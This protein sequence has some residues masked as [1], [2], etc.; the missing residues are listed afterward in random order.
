MG[1]G[2]VRRRTLL[3]LPALA[4]LSAAASACGPRG[5][6]NGK[7]THEFMNPIMNSGADPWVIASGGEYYLTMT[8]GSN[9][10]IWRSSALTD[11]AQ[12]ASRVVWHP[13]AGWADIWAP[14]LHQI[15][16]RWYVYFA[17]DQGGKNATHRMYVLE[18]TDPMGLY[19]PAGKIASPDDHWAIDGTVLTLRDKLYFIWSGWEGSG[20][21]Q[22]L[23]I[24]PMGSPTAISGTRVQISAPTYPWETSAAPINEGPEVL[25]HGDTVFVIYSANASWTNHYCLGQLTLRGSDPLQ[26]SSWVK[27]PEPVFQSSGSVYGPGHAS[28]T[29]SPRGGQHWIVY[30]AARYSG[31]GWTRNVRTQPFSFTAAGQPDFG[32]PQPTSALLGA[33][34]G[35]PPYRTLVAG[36][37]SGQ[38]YTFTAS[39]PRG[40]TYRLWI[41]YSNASLAASAGI[42]VNGQGSQAVTLEATGA[43]T[44]HLVSVSSLTLPQGSS[45]VAISTQTAPFA[46]IDG[47][48]LSLETV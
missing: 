1:D 41:H 46:S 27:S 12:G 32:T 24:A 36:Q 47:V 38:G 11:I 25:Q 14:E 8:T 20:G 19:T 34:E 26:S 23:Y 17:A 35:E 42:T 22:N 13:P 37:M 29:I 2:F 21:A 39:A 43:T 3:G 4:L 5:A 16:G 31:A 7:A 28:Y 9:V 15:N 30:H 18:S 10:T 45:H 44:S 48:W 33:P 40:G 6:S